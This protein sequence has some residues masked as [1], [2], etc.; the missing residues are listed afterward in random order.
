[1]NGDRWLVNSVPSP[2]TDHPSLLGFLLDLHFRAILEY[3]ADRAVTAG[4]HVVTRLDAALDLHVS[5]VR[6]AGRDFDPVRFPILAH[7]EHPFDDFLAFRFLGLLLELLIA[8]LSGVVA[9]V[10]RSL[11]LFAL[12]DFLRA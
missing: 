8:E 4:D 7:R 2:V 3:A 1:M 11:L 10:G 9:L 12:L 5:V 6:D